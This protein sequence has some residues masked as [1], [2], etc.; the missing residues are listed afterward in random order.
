MLGLQTSDGPK[1]PRT[2]MLHICFFVED[3]DSAN[4]TEVGKLSFLYS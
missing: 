1:T 4:D 3:E 2:T